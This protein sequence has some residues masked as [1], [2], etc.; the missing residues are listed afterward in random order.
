MDV[1]RHGVE[2]VVVLFDYILHETVNVLD[3]IHVGN[4]PVVCAVDEGV[5][6]IAALLLQVVELERELAALA[7]AERYDGVAVQHPDRAQGDAA[8][9]IHIDFVLQKDVFELGL[10]V[11]TYRQARDA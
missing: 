9:A 10:G 5:F 8:D 7:L 3:G 1:M 4:L 11:R 6:E 2:R